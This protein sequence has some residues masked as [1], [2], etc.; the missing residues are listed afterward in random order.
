MQ[1][2][3]LGNVIST[4]AI[5]TTILQFFSGALVCKQYVLNKTT[6]ESSSLP[7][8]CGTLC[9]CLWYL[10]GSYKKDD[11]IILVNI[12]GI[13]LMV[14]YTAVFYIYTFKKSTVL[15]Q[16]LCLLFFLSFVICYINVEDD[17]QALYVTLGFVASLFTL[18]T[19]AAPLSKLLHVVRVNSTECLPFPMILMSFFVSLLWFLYGTIQN[20]IFLWLTN[21]VGAILAIIQLSLFAIYPNKS[22]SPSLMK[23]IVE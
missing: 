18:V 22:Q 2:T 12:I 14:I 16:I 13:T 23:N 10:Y 8:V 7:F 6:A 3:T 9:C 15:K 17:I 11:V 4:L 21:L 1:V 20:D 19:I 5:T